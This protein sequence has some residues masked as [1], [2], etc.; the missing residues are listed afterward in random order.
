MEVFRLTALK[1]LRRA[2]IDRTAQAEKERME[3]VRAIHAKPE[4]AKPKGTKAE[5]VNSD[6]PPPSDAT[7]E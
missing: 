1:E 5:S 2:E 4:A 7:T 6:A 3:K